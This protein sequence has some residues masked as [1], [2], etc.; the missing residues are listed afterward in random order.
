MKPRSSGKEDTDIDRVIGIMEV[1]VQY[2]CEFLYNLC[3]LCPHQ[4]SA[5]TY[6]YI[7]LVGNMINYVQVQLRMIIDI[8]NVYYSSLFVRKIADRLLNY[9]FTYFMIDQV[10]LFVWLRKDYIYVCTN[11]VII[12]VMLQSLTSGFEHECYSNGK[13]LEF[14]L[15]RWSRRSHGSAN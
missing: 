3:N 1:Q 15:H 11:T 9:V 2:T 6:M 13:S 14:R 12:F 4:S 8:D 10:F 5:E 7:Q